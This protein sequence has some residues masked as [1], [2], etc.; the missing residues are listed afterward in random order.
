MYTS[1]YIFVLSA[2]IHGHCH[3]HNS[4]DDYLKLS[5]MADIYP[6]LMKVKHNKYICKQ[7][8]DSEPCMTSC[9]SRV[10]NGCII[11]RTQEEIKTLIIATLLY[12]SQH[13]SCTYKG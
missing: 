13:V 4:T 8:L 6:E 5:N 11:Y 1:L 9:S 10:Q 3:C 2:I 7:I 12:G